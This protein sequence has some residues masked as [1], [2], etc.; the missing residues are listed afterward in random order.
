MV[1]PRHSASSLRWSAVLA[2]LAIAFVLGI[3]VGYWL[4]KTPRQMA[5]VVSVSQPERPAND[6]PAAE[7]GSAEPTAVLQLPTLTPATA[8]ENG[9][10]PAQ[11]A[12]VA[13]VIDDLGRS[14]I[15][16]EKLHQLGIPMSYAVLP[17][18]SK[19]SEV[20]EALKEHESE[21]LCHLPMEPRN[22]A[23]PGPGALTGNMSPGELAQATRSALVQIPQAAGV[24]NHMGSGLSTD[25]QAMRPIL[26]VV[27]EQGLFYVDSRTSAE[28]LGYRLA[29]E[30]GIP[31]A[32]RQ[33]FLDVVQ[34]ETMVRQQ[35]RTLLE[36]AQQRGAAIAIGHPSA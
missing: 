20:V 13:L 30:L 14:V 23:N 35:F 6:R 18:E 10:P 26:D 29:L 22:G 16:V 33:V 11:G 9:F 2:A 5:P 4:G 15:Q 34:E 25:P 17:F 3:V 32:E 27:A 36:T 8:E 1:E 7:R 28:S 19:T 21:I 12:R 31:A 24:N